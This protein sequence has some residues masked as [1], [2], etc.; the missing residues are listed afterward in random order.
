[1]NVGYIPPYVNVLRE[2]IHKTQTFVKL[3][4]VQNLTIHEF[5]CLDKVI[6]EEEKK[7][8]IGC[9][10]LAQVLLLYKFYK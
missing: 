5:L 2:S 1:M 9:N 6:D 7:G 10:R 4:L 3:P 8:Q